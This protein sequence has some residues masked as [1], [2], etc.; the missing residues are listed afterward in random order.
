MERMKTGDARDEFGA[1][2]NRVAYGN[3]WIVLERRGKEMAAM[4]PMRDL[5]LLERLI[6]EEEDRMDLASARKS[7]EEPGEN[8]PYEQIRKEM[9]I[10]ELSLGGETGRKENVKKLAKG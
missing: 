9:E 2:V 8:V 10:D 6:E 1:V 4:I 3:E 5:R 7:M